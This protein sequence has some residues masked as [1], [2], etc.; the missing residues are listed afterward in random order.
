MSNEECIL[1]IVDYDG[2]S[3]GASLYRQPTFTNYLDAVEKAK[4][5]QEQYPD[6]KYYILDKDVS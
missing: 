4:I 1:Y 2:R 3:D 6:R 5:L